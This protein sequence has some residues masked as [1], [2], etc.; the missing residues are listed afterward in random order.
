ML[1][2]GSFEVGYQV[3]V[4]IGRNVTGLVGGDHLAILSPIDK[5]VTLIGRGDEVRCCVVGIDASARDGAAFSRI[6]G[7]G[8][9]VGE[10]GIR[11]DCTSK[12]GIGGEIVRVG[13]E[14]SAIGSSSEV[15]LHTNE[16][17]GGGDDDRVFNGDGGIAVE[18]KVIDF[19]QEL[20]V[21][22]HAEVAHGDVTGQSFIGAEIHRILL[23]GAGR[24]RPFVDHSKAGGVGVRSGYEDAEMLGGVVGP[25]GLGPQGERA[26]KGYLG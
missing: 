16:D 26:S 4:V 7:N 18:L 8:D 1:D 9:G 19:D 22:F 25:I 6:G 11:G 21:V 15:G 17:C 10:R 2:R 14:G 24:Q 5:G 20:V 3:A 13:G 12:D 23:P